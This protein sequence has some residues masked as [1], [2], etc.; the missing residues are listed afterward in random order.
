[1]SPDG[2]FASVSTPSYSAL[3]ASS[4]AGSTATDC[5]VAQLVLSG[6]PWSVPS[7]LAVASEGR[8][9]DAAALSLPLYFATAY[10]PTLVGFDWGAAYAAAR[11][12]TA[13]ARSGILPSSSPFNSL[14]A[15][16]IGSTGALVSAAAS[17]STGVGFRVLQACTDPIYESATVC[18]A[19]AAASVFK[20]IS[21]CPY[22]A[23]DQCR[24]CPVGAMC[25][26]G[27]TLLPLPGYW[28][29][30]STSGP[31][32]LVKCQE[33]G[34]SARCPGWRD[35][36]TSSSMNEIGCGSGYRGPGCAACSP[37]FFLGSGECTACPELGAGALL[38][39]IGPIL[40]FVGVLL[41]ASAILIYVVHLL[42]AT[43]KNAAIASASI[44]AWLWMAG[45]SSASAF[46]VTQAFAPKYVAKFYVA[47]TSLQFQGISLPPACYSSPPYM[48]AYVAGGVGL[49]LMLT[50]ALSA[51]VISHE[52]VSQAV[53]EVAK[54]GSDGDGDGNGN[55]AP[56]QAQQTHFRA[57]A[58]ACTLLK[59]GYG[60]MSAAF[61]DTLAC[62]T[63]STQPVRVY[64]NLAHDGAALRA[65]LDNPSSP[66]S[67]ALSLSLLSGSVAGLAKAT[68]S[69][70]ERAVGNPVY[71]AAYG[72]DAALSA[73]ISF[74]LV[75]S[76]SFSVCFEGAHRPAW[77]TSAFVGFLI[78]FGLP[79]LGLW[80]A[81]VLTYQ[82]AGRL[83]SRIM[84]YTMREGA[85]REPD[86]PVVAPARTAFDT[87]QRAVLTSLVDV[88]IRRDSTWIPAAQQTMLV[89]L[90]VS[91]SFAA[92]ATSTV[93][94]SGLMG[95]SI[96]APLLY[97]GAA[98]WKDPYRGSARWKGPA[99]AALAILS[100][101]T[102]GCSLVI[103]LSR[104][105]DRV[106]ST[107][108]IVPL[109]IALTT[110]SA[111][112]RAWWVATAMDARKQKLIA[113]GGGDGRDGRVADGRDFVPETT[114][115]LRLQSRRDQQRSDVTVSPALT[116]FLLDNPLL[117]TLAADEAKRRVAAS[118][119]RG[120]TAQAAAAETAEDLLRILNQLK[121]A[122]D[123]AAAVRRSEERHTLEPV[124][125]DDDV[126]SVMT[127]E[128]VATDDDRDAHMSRGAWRPI[129]PSGSRL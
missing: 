127:V 125:D 84:H 73:P 34:A 74:A 24:P 80:A 90:S 102:A 30:L 27:F 112:L 48:D 111:I 88:D 61:S 106:G 98:L 109:V 114:N 81:N 72:L 38:A 121:D 54:E 119:Q 79:A 105:D 44:A 71:S 95:L 7:I 75:L 10:A 36:S 63:P 4:G 101:V 21:G 85:T 67:A 8:V 57:L 123:D 59:L 86:A 49:L 13:Y 69:D 68:V 43:W 118:M 62:D 12:D 83:A 22:G 51:V 122:E 28:I 15:I 32:D 20:S 3:C 33:P 110:V 46:R 14:G 126:A 23:G 117:K 18:S 129:A 91:A 89:T 96:I 50:V 29:P 113:E 45:Q 76:D 87:L 47:L 2:A 56:Q 41:G 31:G 103:F 53:E 42:G 64:L 16:A 52:P 99:E 78:I 115:P 120:A 124:V 40:L 19:A 92:R 108:S 97:A 25:P 77:I 35:V 94:F 39:V 100:A 70:L 1:M 37:R 128:S 65:A 26:G 9:G 11:A 58:I 82:C 116:R 17:A 60:P 104:G 6:H 93:T 66:V 5:G 55:D 107:V